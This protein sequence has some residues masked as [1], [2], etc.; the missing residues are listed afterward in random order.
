MTSANGLAKA[1]FRAGLQSGVIMGTADIC[2]Q[3]GL[4]K[5]QFDAKRTARWAS[6]GLLIHGPYFY[7]GFSRIDNYFGTATSFG[8][9]LQK[10]VTAQVVLFAPYLT[11]LFSYMGVVEG[12]PDITQ[13]VKQQVPNA[14]IVGAFYWPV[15]NSLNFALVPAS[16]RVPYLAAA[17]GFWNGYLSWSNAKGVSETREE[18]VS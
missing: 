14:F 8:I 11:L 10:T 3:L 1:M 7:Y 4:E 12:H 18:T 13:K 2:T 15:A 17:A 5:R 6:A 16:L 9:V